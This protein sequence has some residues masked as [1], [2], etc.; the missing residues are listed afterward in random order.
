MWSGSS[1]SVFFVFK[2][3]FCL[4]F[5]F[6]LFVWED[7]SYFLLLFFSVFVEDECYFQFF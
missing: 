7:F 1:E 5:V 2:E 4:R 6:C 3:L